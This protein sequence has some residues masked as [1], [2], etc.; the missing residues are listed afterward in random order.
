MRTVSAAGPST[1]RTPDWAEA[2]DDWLTAKRVGRRAGDRG[3]SD[4]ARCGDLIRWADAINSV[5][6]R[7]PEIVDG[8]LSGWSFIKT[9][10]GDPD[11]LLRALDLLG[12]DLASSTRQRMLSTLRG[13]CGYLVRRGLLEHDPTLEPE[14]KVSTSSSN[15]I[16]G[17]TE[18]DIALLIGAAEDEPGPRER[19]RWPT[20]DVAMIQTLQHCGLRVGETCALSI[21]SFSTVDDSPIMRVRD[22]KGG[23]SRSVPVPSPA[24]TALER[25]HN[26]RVEVLGVP[27]ETD[28][29][30]VRRDGT[31][32][33]QQAVD[34][35]LRGLANR[36]G[37]SVP[38]GAM[39]HALRHSYGDRLARR[40]VPLPII[41]QLMGHADPRTT[42]IYTTVHAQELTLALRN[43]GLT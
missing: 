20:R 30:F 26:D 18:T 39:A 41:Q 25:W 16:L 36:S 22:G 8:R 23:K 32:L 13:F 12:N 43:A 17:F 15:T 14:L 6:G 42:S 24:R 1:R 38:D 3:H 29:L 11:V 28:R 37:V 35:L 4:R 2:A 40:G 7:Q 19:A 31:P 5:Q 9:E 10:L 21:R 33:N 34:R 27:G